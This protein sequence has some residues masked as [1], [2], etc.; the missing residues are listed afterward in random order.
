MAIAAY[1][2]S[3]EENI[4]EQIKT[5]NRNALTPLEKSELAKHFVIT[6]P[7]ISRRQQ[8]SD[9]TLKWLIRLADGQEVETVYNP[10]ILIIEWLHN[11]GT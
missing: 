2:D 7:S 1:L 3:K 6:R 10:H 5:F 4:Q 9:G 11:G 8:S